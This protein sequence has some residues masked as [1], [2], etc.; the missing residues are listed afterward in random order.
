M[1]GLLC[2][3]IMKLFFIAHLPIMLAIMLV[4]LTCSICAMQSSSNQELGS[5]TSCHHAIKDFA[6]NSAATCISW[7]QKADDYIHAISRSIARGISSDALELIDDFSHFSHAH[8]PQGVIHWQPRVPT[9]TTYLISTMIIH[10]T[11]HEHED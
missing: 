3:R 6:A 10:L 9:Y 11:S 4:S 2:R 7:S 8:A 1:N 5:L